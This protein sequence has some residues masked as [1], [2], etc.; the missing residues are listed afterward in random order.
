MIINLPPDTHA[1][2][3]SLR[4]ARLGDPSKPMTCGKC[5]H[6][7]PSVSKSCDYAERPAGQ[8]DAPACIEFEVAP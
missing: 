3:L 8:G 5:A 1:T 2:E 7:I 6:F 4:F